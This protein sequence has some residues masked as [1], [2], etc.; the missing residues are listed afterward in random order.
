MLPRRT[1]PSAWP[2]AVLELRKPRSAMD[3][4]ERGLGCSPFVAR[5]EAL[6]RTV[7]VRLASILWIMGAIS[8]S[9]HSV[10]AQED[11]VS[12]IQHSADANERDSA[13]VPKFDNSERDRN[14]DGD[15]TYAVTMLHGHP[16]ERLIAVNGRTSMLQNKKKNSTN[17][18]KQSRNGGTSL[19]T[20]DPKESPNTRQTGIAITISF[21]K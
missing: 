2:R 21:S 17:M 8:L 10:K 4:R 6:V 11:V 19:R 5:F 1:E 12:I 18:R 3:R 13:A 14:K 20:S 15:K 7:L 9:P 16:F